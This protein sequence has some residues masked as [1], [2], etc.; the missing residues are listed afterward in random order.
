VQP[1]ARPSSAADALRPGD[2][3][4]VEIGPVAHGGHCVARF[5]GR[6]IFVRLSLPGE[7]ARVRITEVRKGS[8]CRADAIEIL[9]A[10][11]DRVDAPCVH[12]GPGGCG[13]CDFQH[14]SGAKQR[15]L[16]AT[17]V[18]EQL[19]RLAGLAV[20]VVVEEIPGGGFGWRTRVRW[21]LDP[22]GRIGPRAVRSHRVVAVNPSAPCLIAAPGLTELAA[23]TDVPAGV[24]R[25]SS[26]RGGSQTTAR[27]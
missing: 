23:T 3:V 24:R 15:A 10:D 27:P 25:P 26:G 20:P 7:L 14:A 18:S 11:A 22:E 21:A 1:G 6:V 2:V 16:K 19:Q 9:R 12:F 13:G 8:F 5:E 4:V 17:V